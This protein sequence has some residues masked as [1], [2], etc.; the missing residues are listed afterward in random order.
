MAHCSGVCGADGPE[1]VRADVSA[2]G[3]GCCEWAPVLVFAGVSN[4]DVV[5]G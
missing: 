5:V 3:C 2:V 1:Q 4:D